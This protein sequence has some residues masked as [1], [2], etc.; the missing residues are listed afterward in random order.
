MS[1]SKGSASGLRDNGSSRYGDVR[2]CST[3]SEISGSSCPSSTSCSTDERCDRTVVLLGRTGAGKST[4]ANVLADE[5]DLFKTSGGSTSE[6]KEMQ[7]EIVS[8]DWPNKTYK[9]KIVDTIG[10][11]D[12][13]L[14][15]HEVLHR[16]ALTCHECTD[17]INAV[18]FLVKNRFEDKEADAWDMFTQVLFGK[19]IVD[20]TAI[21]KTDFAEFENS[22]ATE[23]DRRKLE[24][25]DKA[26]K[27]ILSGIKHFI[28]VDNPTLKYGSVSLAARASSRKKLLEHIIEKCEN[29]FQPPLL[30]E[31]HQRISVYVQQLEEA[32]EKEEK[33]E[34]EIKQCKD[35]ITRQQLE[36]E[37]EEIKRQ[38]AEAKAEIEKRMRLAVEDQ[39]RAAERIAAAEREKAATERI[40]A[41]ERE[42]AATERIAAAEREKAAN[43]I[44]AAEKVAAA[45]RAATERI[46]AAEIAAAKRAAA[47]EKE[48]EAEKAATKKGAAEEFLGSVAGATGR[49][50]DRTATAVVDTVKDCSV[51]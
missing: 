50:A 40:A 46:A 25:E 5:T 10:I 12:T 45:E 19:E 26:T 37:S 38:K 32:K 11:G 34:A 8:V 41:A 9:V 30:R 16:L 43:E 15:Q 24:E 3:S 20:Y 14:S 44:A 18:F 21:V 2:S 47:T 13:E 23:A 36:K 29:V 33:L 51:M 49:L 48:A 17:G 35:V 1:F 39:V 4:C 27:R 42:K 22:E 31:V 6:T 7:R 28:Y